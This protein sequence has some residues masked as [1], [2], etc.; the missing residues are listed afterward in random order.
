VVG[1]IAPALGDQQELD[2]QSCRQLTC[3]GRLL[4]GR[5]SG[6]RTGSSVS[7]LRDECY[8]QIRLYLQLGEDV[9]PSAGGEGAASVFDYV[10]A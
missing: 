7:L 4:R 1:I 5:L 10:V 8:Q 3:V 9:F 2:K 6:W